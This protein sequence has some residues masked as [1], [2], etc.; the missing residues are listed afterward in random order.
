[1][2]CGRR[3]LD[4]VLVLRAG[5]KLRYAAFLNF[6][7]IALVLM[8]LGVDEGK[9]DETL[10]NHR[11]ETPREYFD[12]LQEVVKEDWGR[13]EGTLPAEPPLFNQQ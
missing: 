5:R 7:D 6:E 1:M 13:I 4:A 8:A 10:S 3:L 12:R 9:A 11:E 2:V